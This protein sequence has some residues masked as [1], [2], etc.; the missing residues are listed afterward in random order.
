MLL[1]DRAPEAARGRR[2]WTTS[3]SSTPSPSTRTTPRS[4]GG[5]ARSSR[6][7]GPDTREPY[8]RALIKALHAIDVQVIAGYEIVTKDKGTT[9]QS[10]AFTRWLAM[11]SPSQI[12]AHANAIE[13]FFADRGLGID[14]IGFDFEVNGLGARQADSLKLLFQK[15][16]EAMAQRNGLVSYANAPFQEDGV[17]SM[18]FMR[19]QPF[20]LASQAPNL[21][22]RP[23]CFDDKTA[24]SRGDVEGSVACALRKRKYRALARAKREQRDT[25]ARVPPLK[26]GGG[27]IRRRPSSPSGWARPAGTRWRSGAARS[28]GRTGSA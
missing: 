8:L 1:D 27:S 25:G 2:A 10:E 3:R 7:G 26:E 5:P 16:S 23:M 22:A 24:A 4:P 11:A 20:S 19:A 21:V 18:P 9:P 13:A 15:T 6:W 17:S 28:S 12:E 14:G